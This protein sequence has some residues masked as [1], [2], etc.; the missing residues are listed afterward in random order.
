MEFSA[1]KFALSSREEADPVDNVDTVLTVRLTPSSGRR[2]EL[3]P[4]EGLTARGSFTIDWGDG[5]TSEVNVEEFSVDGGATT[6][7][8]KRSVYHMYSAYGQYVV[9]ISDDIKSIV[10]TGGS[11]YPDYSQPS[12]VWSSDI[13]VT[14]AL[15]S[16]DSLAP[17]L[18]SL[19]PYGLSDSLM[20]TGRR[21]RHVGAGV[22]IGAYGFSRCAGIKSFEQAA[23]AFASAGEGAFSECRALVTLAGM[24]VLSPTEDK[25]FMGCTALPSIV[26]GFASDV[27]GLG[28]SIFERCSA[29]LNLT[30]LPSSLATLG[31]RAFAH[32]TSLATLSAVSGTALTRYPDFCFYHCVALTGLAGSSAVTEFGASCFER[33]R[34]VTSFSGSAPTKCGDRCFAR[35]GMTTVGGVDSIEEFGDECFAECPGIANLNLLS[36]SL[37]TVGVGCFR[38]CFERTWTSEK[39]G[40]EIAWVL[41]AQRGLSDISGVSR[42]LVEDLSDRCFYG[43]GNLTALPNWSASETIT[44]IGRYCFAGCI[45]LSS[46]DGIPEALGNSTG[47]DDMET[48]TGDGA[49]IDEG[50][51]ADCYDRPHAIPGTTVGGKTYDTAY[52]GLVDVSAIA[53]TQLEALSDHCFD[54]C[55]LIPD[56]PPLPPRLYWMG[57]YCFSRC[58]NLATLDSVADLAVA[59]ASIGSAAGV[60]GDRHAWLPHFGAYCFADCAWSGDGNPEDAAPDNEEMLYVSDPSNP[61]DINSGGLAYIGGVRAYCDKLERL[62]LFESEAVHGEQVVSLYQALYDTVMRSLP[63]ETT[64]TEDVYSLLSLMFATPGSY[65]Q[66]TTYDGSDIWR[67]ALGDITGRR[68]LICGTAESSSGTGYALRRYRQSVISVLKPD[69]DTSTGKMTGLTIETPLAVLS[70]SGGTSTTD[71]SDV[72]VVFLDN[73]PYV[74]GVDSPEVVYSDSKYLVLRTP[75]VENPLTQECYFAH[76][77]FIQAPGTIPQM[78]YGVLLTVYDQNVADLSTETGKALAGSVLLAGA[79]GSWSGGGE[80][81]PVPSLVGDAYGEFASTWLRRT[82]LGLLMYNPSYAGYSRAS[83]I[84]DIFDLVDA[85]AGKAGFVNE[86]R[87]QMLLLRLIGTSDTLF[88]KGCFRGCKSLSVSD[89]TAVRPAVNLD[90]FPAVAAMVPD[91]CFA[92]SGVALTRAFRFVRSIG[93]GAFSGSSVSEFG[94]FPVAVS[95]VPSECF[96]G[97]LGV[98]ALGVLRPG[99]TAYADG[100]FDG[101]TALADLTYTGSDSAKY[102][103]RDGS[104]FKNRFS[105]QYSECI[106]QYVYSRHVETLGPRVFRGTAVE[107]LKYDLEPP[108]FETLQDA[109]GFVSAVFDEL[110]VEVIAT[111]SLSASYLH[112]VMRLRAGDWGEPELVLAGEFA[113]GDITDQNSTVDNQPGFDMNGAALQDGCLVSVDLDREDDSYTFYPAYTGSTPPYRHIWTASD[114]GTGYVTVDDYPV[115]VCCPSYWRASRTSSQSATESVSGSYAYLFIG[116]YRFYVEFC[117]AVDDKLVTQNGSSATLDDISY[118][119][120]GLKVHSFTKTADF[121]GVLQVPVF[122]LLSDIGSGCF[123]DCASLQGLEGL[124]SSVHTLP[125]RCFAGCPFTHDV[126]DPEVVTPVVNV[127]MPVLDAR[128]NWRKMAVGILYVDYENSTSN[129]Q[130]LDLKIYSRYRSP[131]TDYIRITWTETQDPVTGVYVLSDPVLDPDHRVLESFAVDS[132]TAVTPEAT[133]MDGDKILVDLTPEIK[134]TIQ[135]AASGSDGNRYYRI[136]GGDAVEFAGDSLEDEM[137]VYYDACDGAVS[138]DPVRGNDFVYKSAHVEPTGLFGFIMTMNWDRDDGTWDFIGAA[139]SYPI[140]NDPENRSVTFD[141]L[142]HGDVASGDGYYQVWCDNHPDWTVRYHVVVEAVQVRANSVEVPVSVSQVNADCFTFDQYMDDG[143]ELLEAVYFNG[144]GGVSVRGMSGFPF[145]IPPGCSIYVGGA[146]IYTEPLPG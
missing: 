106:D 74:P 116:P 91:Y 48:P 140:I 130:Y 142:N 62:M 40:A 89:S 55:A 122:P 9:R 31:D 18:E 87:R 99:L 43:D 5:S 107:S 14:A 30:G 71:L 96:S 60:G 73:P 12:G 24:S 108:E 47:R 59:R 132:V 138:A 17:H 52:D 101:C 112:F 118:E 121:N 51:F 134:I 114:V 64:T 136:A 98:S 6:L 69:I 21:I 103:D 123:E 26:G 33:T 19:M 44:R 85:L 15:V 53:D 32:C 92:D 49:G 102:Q 38:D 56:L 139:G 27:T 131:L 97:C 63:E 109:Q 93:R 128:I 90:G 70:G 95:F 79:L 145:G 82:I 57:D 126:T 36:N 13:G 65:I 54:G 25:T 58:R 68:R 22:A 35:S 77:S 39:R 120:K 50:A 86:L 117:F 61:P 75:A 143:R 83:T 88:G 67:D 10:L 84:A 80:V 66:G 78:N 8:G 72:G 105:P 4:F 144:R 137:R 110:N 119:L 34:L 29:L 42:T 124:P 2:I 135:L 7:V 81:A 141:P 23:M 46:I 45:G 3:G 100:A 11:H 111:G 129:G 113:R 16:V 41:T 125:S 20:L 76:E 127:S 146:V 115:R 37:E 133:G 94:E 104:M 1:M 28:A